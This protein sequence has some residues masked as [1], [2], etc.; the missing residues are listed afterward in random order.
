MFS[1]DG[2]LPGPQCDNPVEGG[3]LFF[4]LLSP[5][6]WLAIQRGAVGSELVFFLFFFLRVMPL[7]SAEQTL[8]ATGELLNEGCRTTGDFLVAHK[9]LK[10][11]VWRK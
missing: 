3:G 4:F 10:G 2:R 1:A 9:P 7:L 5:Q 8:R 6:T 11:T